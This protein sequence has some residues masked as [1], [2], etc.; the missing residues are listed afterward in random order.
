MNRLD[1]SSYRLDPSLDSS[2]RKAYT[3]N[4]LREPTQ[5]FAVLT[6]NNPEL[7]VLGQMNEKILLL[8]GGFPITMNGEVVGGVGVAAHPVLI[9]MKCVPRPR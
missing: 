3:S 9:T 2:F 5:R 1:P 8:G 4:S 6:A 7:S